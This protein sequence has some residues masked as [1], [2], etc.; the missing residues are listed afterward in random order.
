MMVVLNNPA[1]S[2]FRTEQSDSLWITDDINLKK[3]LLWR[4]LFPFL[5]SDHIT[6][7]L[8]VGIFSEWSIWKIT[9]SCWNLP[10]CLCPQQLTSPSYP[11]KPIFTI[12]KGFYNWWLPYCMFSKYKGTHHQWFV[13]G[14]WRGLAKGDL[15]TCSYLHVSNLHY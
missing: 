10:R 2:S 5:S 7:S 9:K 4:F 12:N 1:Q 15:H 13:A 14:G 11:V 8:L 6:D 3:L